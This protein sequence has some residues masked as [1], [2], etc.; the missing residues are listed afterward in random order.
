MTR[1]RTL[2]LTLLTLT[3]IY[4]YAF[5]SATIPYLAIVLGHIAGGLVFALVLL[6]CL[7]RLRQEDC[8]NHGLDIHRHWNS[9]G[10]V[11]GVHRCN[12]AADS[13]VVC[14]HLC[15][16]C[17]SPVPANPSCGTPR[18]ADPFWCAA[19]HCTVA[20]DIPRRRFG[21]GSPGS[22]MARQLQDRKPR[23]ATG[24]PGFRGTRGPRRLLSSSVRT[25]TG[26]R[27]G[28]E[29]F[30]HRRRA[31]AVTPTSTNS[32]TVRPTTSPRSIMWY[33]KSI[34]YYRTSTALSPRDGVPAATIRLCCSAASSTRQS[35][36]RRHAGSAG[37]T[38]MCDVPPVSSV[39]STM[40]QGDFTLEHPALAKLAANEN[41]DA[42][43]AR[44]PRLCKSRTA[45][46]NFHEAIHQEQNAEFCSTC[47]KVHLDNTSQLPM[48]T[49]LQRLRQLA[50]QRGRPGRDPFTIRLKPGLR[51]LSHANPGFQ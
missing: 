11:S 50:G 31:S 4:L 3:G 10:N 26:G 48:D 28:A 29:F 22:R 37:R 18:M 36:D 19:F 42:H 32:G 43:A 13:V 8:R 17:R 1:L 41:A 15:L 25:N 38:R 49:R 16:H 34:E 47:H 35:A 21:M 2:G 9:T 14:A 5:P 44:F 23:H 6:L 39:N 12:Q 20:A 33:R 7:R 40:G 51:R 27:L 46:A 24:V 45:P 30:R